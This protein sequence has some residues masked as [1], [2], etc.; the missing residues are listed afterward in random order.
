MNMGQRSLYLENSYTM[1]ADGSAVLHVRQ[2]PPN[3]ALFPPGPAFLFVVVNGVPSNATM[4]MVGNGQL[5]AQP[6]LAPA[7]LP[8]TVALQPSSTG[9]DG[10]GSSAGSSTQ[11]NSGKSSASS[12]LASAGSL[13][14]ACVAVVVSALASLVA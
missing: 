7:E 14:L 12:Q 5:G 3:A 1:N 4:V 8:G 13:A 6:M 10:P 2:M 11:S 9:P